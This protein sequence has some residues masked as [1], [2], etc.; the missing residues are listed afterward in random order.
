MSFTYRI[1]LTTTVLGI[2]I[3]GLSTGF[4][5]A[6]TA[7]AQTYPWCTQ[8]E[9]LQCYYMN[10]AQCEETVDYHG[11]CVPNPDDRQTEHKRG[12]P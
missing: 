6:T 1:C 12:A 3:A 7:H 11:F 8:G 4:P 9:N 10:R 2:S 5:D